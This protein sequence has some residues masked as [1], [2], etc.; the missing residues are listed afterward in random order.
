MEKLI[1]AVQ[2]EWAKAKSKAEARCRR[3]GKTDLA[4]KLAACE[5]FLGIETLPELVQLMFSPQG[6]EFMTSF[7]FPSIEIFRQFKPYHPEKLGVYIDCGNISLTEAR[8][9][10]L[11]GDT[12]AELKYRQTAQN[13]VNLMCGAK[14]TITASGYSVIKIES[15]RNS[16]VAHIITDHAIVL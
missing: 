15:D 11:V 4:D 16:Q 10:F 9:A 12:T 14:A 13:R 3:I 1:K 8:N 2:A 6:I 5:M 7:N